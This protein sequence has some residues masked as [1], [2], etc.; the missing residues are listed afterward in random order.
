MLREGRGSGQPGPRP[1]PVELPFAE[2]VLKMHDLKKA[3]LIVD[4]DLDQP[5][6][7]A[8]QD[9]RKM[10]LEI[11]KQ[12]L[13]DASSTVMELI[14]RGIIHASEREEYHA[15]LNHTLTEKVAEL[16]K[17]HFQSQ[18]VFADEVELLLSLMEKTS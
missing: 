8:I 12:Q 3:S 10:R 5:T 17:R 16:E 9:L 7:E 13:K 1:I 15:A 14:K 6:M 2:W 11:A 18:A 4:C